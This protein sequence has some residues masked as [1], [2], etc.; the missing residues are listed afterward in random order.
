M[1]A[2]GDRKMCINVRG[3]ADQIHI[4]EVRLV[5]I[6]LYTTAITLSEAFEYIM[7]F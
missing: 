2:H 1:A 6:L 3:V 7:Y 4:V 5:L